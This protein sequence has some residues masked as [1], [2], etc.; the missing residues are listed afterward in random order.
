MDESA[1][2]DESFDTA[3]KTFTLPT[4]RSAVVRPVRQSNPWD[5]NVPL[6]KL[7][8]L[9]VVLAHHHSTHCASCS[10]IAVQAIKIDQPL[11]W[12]WPS[13][14]ARA[15]SLPSPTFSRASSQ[16][17]FVEGVFKAKDGS[18]ARLMTLCLK[19]VELCRFQVIYKQWRTLDCYIQWISHRPYDILLKRNLNRSM[20]SR[21]RSRKSRGG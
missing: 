12:L 14:S 18:S 8:V 4:F 21:C 6:H 13:G 10:Y 20:E 3:N 17:N 19:F 11:F 16:S 5:R 9:S 1:L 2:A 15:A 7:H